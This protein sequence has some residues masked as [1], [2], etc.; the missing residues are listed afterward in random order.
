MYTNPPNPEEEAD[1]S[2]NPLPAGHLATLHHG[3][4]LL[5]EALVQALG[6]LQELVH[7]AEGAAL[8]AG[9]QGLG[10]E[11]VDTVIEAALDELGVHLNQKGFQLDSVGAW[12]RR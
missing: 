6:A 2:I 10:G 3:G 1:H 8:L 4:I 12:R 7:A 9:D 5:L 11:V